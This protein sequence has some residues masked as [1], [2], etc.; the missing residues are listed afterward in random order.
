MLT[1]V[2]GVTRRNLVDTLATEG[3]FNTLGRALE[4]AELVNVFSGTGPYTIF[5]PTDAAFK[6]LPA[7]TL[8]HWMMPENRAE[9]VAVLRYHV[10]PGR[11]AAID[12]AEL[13]EPRMMQ[14]QTA[15]IT[16]PGETL[17]INDARITQPDIVS[18]N[19]V[20]HGIDTVI[21]PPSKR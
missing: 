12:V 15:A 2:A 21:V 13:K 7:G 14:G 6:K 5:A 1:S 10:L 18:S 8:E 20:I 17:N 4:A 16:M 19:G 3:L 11:S 9:L